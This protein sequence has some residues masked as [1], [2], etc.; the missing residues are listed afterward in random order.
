MAA[1]EWGKNKRKN[2]FANISTIVLMHKR[3]RKVMVLHQQIRF[4]EIKRNLQTG[5]SIFMLRRM[6]IELGTVSSINWSIDCQKKE[7]KNQVLINKNRS[8]CAVFLKDE[9]HS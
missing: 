2:S 7:K 6:R 9:Q 5:S 8:N 4:S 3:R 1:G